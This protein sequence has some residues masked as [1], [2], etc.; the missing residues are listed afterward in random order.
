VL[1]PES[2]R[3]SVRHCRCFPQKESGNKS[4]IESLYGRSNVSNAES[5]TFDFLLRTRERHGEIKQLGGLTVKAGV[6]VRGAKDRLGDSV[7]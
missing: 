4:R 1:I 5:A 7:V 2:P 3:K 6:A